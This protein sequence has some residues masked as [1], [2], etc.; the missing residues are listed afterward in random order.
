MRYSTD[1]EDTIE[2]LEFTE[3]N[4]DEG[5]SLEIM[6]VTFLQKDVG[7]IQEKYSLPAHCILE[8]FLDVN[9]ELL[10]FCSKITAAY[11]KQRTLMLLGDTF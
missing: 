7:F 10:G 5:V 2:I 9:F 4:G 3:K 1:K 11:G 8:D 6:N